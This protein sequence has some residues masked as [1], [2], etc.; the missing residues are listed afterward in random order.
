MPSTS[1]PKRVTRQAA[2]LVVGREDFD[3]VAADAE[4]AAHEAGVAALVLQGHEL[5]EELALVD[6]LALL[7]V[8]GHGGVVFHRADAVDAG[9]RGDDDDVVALEDRARGRVAHAVDLLVDGGFLLDIGVGARDVGLGLVVVVVGDEVLHR[10]VGEE[11]LELRIELGGEGLVGREDERRALGAGDHLGGGE[12][13][14][15]AGDAEEDLVGLAILDAFHQFGDGGGLVAGRHIVGGEAEGLRGAALGRALGA[16]RHPGGGAFHLLAAMEDDL[17]ERFHRG[18]DADGGGVGEVLVL[19]GLVLLDR[20]V[21]GLAQLGLGFRI[22]AAVR[23]ISRAVMALVEGMWPKPACGASPMP[24]KSTRSTELILV[25]PVFF[26]MPV[27]VS[28]FDLVVR[29]FSSGVF[30]SSSRRTAGAQPLPFPPPRRDR[31]RACSSCAPHRAACSPAGPRPFRS[32]QRTRR[33][34]IPPCRGGRFGAMA[35]S[36]VS[37]RGGCRRPHKWGLCHAMSAG[38]RITLV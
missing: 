13:F 30:F 37:R 4:G 20:S 32:R 14:A 10:I 21:E 22:G 33:W 6:L 26:D 8:D 2:G 18:R 27:A 1:L 31:G 9:D 35:R 7:H 29:R 28:L 11:A 5:G 12:G 16:M 25:L 24:S 17:L 36:S 38:E 23:E 3:G 34:K 15:R 19:A